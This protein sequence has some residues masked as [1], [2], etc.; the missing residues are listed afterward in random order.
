MRL[1]RHVS[2]ANV[3]A[4][5]A[6]VLAMSGGALAANHYLITSTSQI[7]PRVLKKLKGNVGAKGSPGQAGANGSQGQAG[8]NGATGAQGPKG[9]DGPKGAN[10]TAGLSALSTLPSGSTESGAY[11]IGAPG[12]AAEEELE[13]TVTFPIPLAEPIPPSRVIYNRLGVVPLEHCDGPGHADKG[14]LCVYSAFSFHVNPPIF[15]ELEGNLE[16]GTGRVGFRLDFRITGE[17]PGDVGTY[18]V[19]AP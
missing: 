13:A 3:A 8:A 9:T 4:T 16:E 1:T 10:G 17:N 5:L 12:G 2:Y 6:L 7:S 19:T 15:T 18:T 14:F 11:G